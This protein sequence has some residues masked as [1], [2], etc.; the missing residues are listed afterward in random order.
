MQ[1]ITTDES[2]IILAMAEFE[3]SGSVLSDKNVIRGWDGK[4]YFD[5]D[6]RATIPDDVRLQQ[7]ANSVRAER[8][9]RIES[10]QWIIQRHLDELASGRDTTLTPEK[11]QEWLQ[12]RQE[13]R[14][15]PA[16]DGFPWGGVDDEQTPWPVEPE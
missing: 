10:T 14:D 7:L 6:P 5:G 8:D 4:L 9:K 12:Y 3:F 13:L 15:L 1:Y 16:Q 11:Y 2:G